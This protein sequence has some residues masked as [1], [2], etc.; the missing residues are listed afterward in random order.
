[1]I[2]IGIEGTAHTLGVGIVEDREI[3]ADVKK[4]YSP[5][6]GGIHPR[7]ASR[8][9]AD[10]FG[11][12]IKEAIEKASI[13][14]NDIDL[15]AFSRGPGLG[16]C[17][18]VAAVGARA[19]S[20][21][22]GKPIIGVNHCISHIEIGNLIAEK[23]HK[24]WNAP[25][26]LYVSGA[27]TQILF[28]KEKRY[29]IFGETLDIG[30]GNMLDKFGRRTGLKH[31]AGPKIEELASKGSKYIELPYVVKGNDLS[32]SGIFTASVN[33]SQ[34]EPLED[35]CYSLQETAFAMTTEATERA[36]CHLKCKNVMLT[37]GVANNK[38]FQKMVG[39]MASDLGCNFSVPKGY[40]GDNGVMIAYTGLVMHN[41]GIRHSIKDT[42]PD[43][44]FRT[45]QVEIEWLK[46]VSLKKEEARFWRGAEA[47]IT[48]NNGTVDKVRKEKHFRIRQIDDRIRKS[49]TKQEAKL[50]SRA[51]EIG[52]R[53]PHV[54]DTGK[55]NICMEFID[56]RTVDRAFEAE[57]DVKQHSSEI[58]GIISRLHDN[59]I[60]HGDL[61]TSNMIL[62]DG[63]LYLIDFG[64]GSFSR[65]PED[66]A[67][68]LLVL[69]KSLN[70][71]HPR[72][73]STIWD[74]ILRNYKPRDKDKI[75]QRLEKAEKRGRYL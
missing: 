20:L 27:N 16:P 52:V 6:D 2:C 21:S 41:S 10:V 71:N 36:L 32:F 1:M 37:G 14:R 4:T 54:K 75:M 31:P 70:A 50:L 61:T 15:V 26:V 65:K 43:Q 44:N 39:E 23:E 58:G 56:G 33:K 7:D 45:D 46:P 66:K 48:R 28:M 8:H 35:V 18:Q 68:D 11:E 60:I 12:A 67:V 5:K 74:N 3:L 59:D 51:S 30:L 62:K 47:V 72:F 73:F 42:V 34:N 9:M 57:K 53:V 29:R 17:L 38:R 19:L 24:D 55:Y 25:L 63:T 13:D 40:C 64:L 69:E 22:L 49:R